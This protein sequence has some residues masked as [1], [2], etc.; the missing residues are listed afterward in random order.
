MMSRRRFGRL[1][2]AAVCLWLVPI[3]VH[4]NLYDVFANK[5]RLDP[6]LIKA[7][8]YVE[9]GG[10]PWTVNM[11]GRPFFFDTKA[12]AILFVTERQHTPCY[13]ELSQK[14]EIRRAWFAELYQA[15]RYAVS[16]SPRAIA[17]CLNPRNV[18]IGLMQ[19]NWRYHQQ[20]AGLTLSEMFDPIFN[21]D[22]ASRFLAGL[23]EKHGIWTG[24]ARYHSN[25]PAN[26]ATYT[27]KVWKAYQALVRDANRKG[28]LPVSAG[29]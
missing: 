20:E 15:Q 23:I 27:R 4:A 16:L 25:R 11:D 2:V 1:I 13:V 17:G 26:Q 22:Y 29:G 14:G 3:S 21:I 5:Y 9:S 7:I 28:L 24:I 8:A 6:Y 18:D 19:I 12:A 10:H